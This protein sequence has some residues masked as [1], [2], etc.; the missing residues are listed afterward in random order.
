MIQSQLTDL[1]TVVDNR[2]GESNQ[3]TRDQLSESN[4]LIKDITTQI[5]QVKETNKQVVDVADQLKTL[6]NILQNPKQRGELGEY[7]LE[8]ILKNVLPPGNYKMQ[9]EFENGSK[10]DA[11]IIFG[12]GDSQK[13]LPVDSKFSLENYNRFVDERD[14]G[15]RDGFE[16]N[17]VEDVKK[18]ISETAKY[19]KPEEKTMDFAFMFIPS[20][21]IYYDLL[22][23][24]VGTSNLIEF[25]FKNRVILVSPT[26]FTAYLQTVLQGLRALKIEESAKDIQKHVLTLGK[27]LQS[28]EDYMRKLGDTLGTSVNHY[29]TAYNELGKIDKDIMRI[30]GESAAIKPVRIEKPTQHLTSE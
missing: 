18:R 13:I 12:N 21:A 7:F 20:E 3:T 11:A 22:I 2:L 16:K 4:R 5:T 24:K 25:A 23:N 27:H 19:V 29:N 14:P 6:Q 10:V 15:R 8:A 9:Y 28:Y 26:S 17:F 1:K 30:T